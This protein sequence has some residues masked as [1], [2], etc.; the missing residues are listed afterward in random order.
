MLSMQLCSSGTFLFSPCQDVIKISVAKALH[1]FFFSF[2]NL[3]LY[4]VFCNRGKASV[5]LMEVQSYISNVALANLPA[6]GRNVTARCVCHHEITQA[7][8][9]LG[10][11]PLY[12]CLQHTRSN[13]HM[14]IRNTECPIPTTKWQGK[15]KQLLP[16]QERSCSS[17]PTA[18]SVTEDV[19]GVCLNYLCACTRL[20]MCAWFTV[21]TRI[22]KVPFPDVCRHLKET[23][24]AC[25][26]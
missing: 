2:W 20:F 3:Q 26:L 15:N 8:W 11:T 5:V 13:Y 22:R 7:F 12:R 17:P 23:I 16:C 14:V 4:E 10:N 25:I 6:S 1:S 24:S 19:F 9:E 18:T 21:H